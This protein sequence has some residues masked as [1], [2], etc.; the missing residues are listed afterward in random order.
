MNKKDNKKIDIYRITISNILKNHQLKNHTEENKF[1]LFLYDDDFNQFKI[2]FNICSAKNNFEENIN[3]LKKI[4]DIFKKSH[5]LI[6]FKKLF[7][8]DQNWYAFFNTNADING[9]ILPNEQRFGVDK[10][11]VLDILIIQKFIR[12]FNNDLDKSIEFYQRL[13]ILFKIHL[14]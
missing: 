14:S 5:N 12:D 11:Y 7:M 3:N 1:Y 8:I 9:N 2:W 13:K 4:I 10:N 6:S